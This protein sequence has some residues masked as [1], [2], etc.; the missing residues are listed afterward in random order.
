MP[1]LHLYVSKEIADEVK[2]RAENEGVSTSRYLAEMVR[3]ECADEWPTGFF[4]TVVGGWK[5]APLVRPEQLP[6]EDRVELRPA[7][8]AE[9][10][11]PTRTADG[12]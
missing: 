10:R 9:K 1:Q 6:A 11:A 2:R 8:A 4:E 3:R 5:G 12:N 7:R